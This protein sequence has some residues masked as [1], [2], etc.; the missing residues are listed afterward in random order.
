MVANQYVVQHNDI[1]CNTI[2]FKTNVVLLRSWFQSIAALFYIT[3]Y[4][5]KAKVQIGTALQANFTSLQYVQ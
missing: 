4:I 5:A 1:L 3:P 2:K